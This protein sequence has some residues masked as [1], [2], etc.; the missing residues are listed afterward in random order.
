VKVFGSLLAALGVCAAVALP[1][2][3]SA[4]AGA[5]SA[6]SGATVVVDFSHFGGGIVSRCAP[7]APE[8]GLDALQEAGFQLTPVARYG[9][10]FI[11]RID[12]WPAHG[13][14][15]DTPPA[16]ASWSYYIAGAS[17][18]SWGFSN[19]GATASTQPPGS[20]EGWA[21]G[22][23]AHVS[24]EPG[25]VPTPPS[26][27]PPGITTKPTPPPTAAPVTPK[28]SPSP[29]SPTNPQPLGPN[30]VVPSGG[31]PTTTTIG[32]TH[33]PPRPATKRVAAKRSA[34][35]S[36]AESASATTV[37]SSVSNAQVVAG[38]APVASTPAASSGTPWPLVATL[39]A[40]AGCGAGAV[41][42]A[43]KRRQSTT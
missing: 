7:H 30:A 4:P 38:A 22:A 31:L 10:A 24:V 15:T 1:A 20:F 34:K 18:T 19:L 27:T 12:G 2:A 21:F 37:P 17:D 42:I 40:L 36:A 13:S 35:Q 39:V 8:S 26:G 23:N 28:G 14:C 25:Q 11:C 5:S 9:L 3:Q 6:C 41:V 33:A 16:N 29:P 32:P 43:R